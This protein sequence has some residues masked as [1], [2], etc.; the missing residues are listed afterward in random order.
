[1]KQI[2]RAPPLAKVPKKY[3][4]ESGETTFIRSAS[5]QTSAQVPLGRWVAAGDRAEVCWAATS[6]ALMSKATGV[7]SK[8][9]YQLMA[10]CSLEQTGSSSLRFSCVGRCS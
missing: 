4:S 8:G 6:R 10:L 2:G 7:C 9:H 1:M 3:S 5:Q